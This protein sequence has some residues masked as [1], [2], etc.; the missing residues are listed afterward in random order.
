MDA[1]ASTLVVI[2][3]NIA[4]ATAGP[5]PGKTPTA[6]PTAHPIKHH[7]KLI[8]V[9]A[10]ANPSMSWFQTSIK[11]TLLQLNLAN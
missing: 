8:G 7:N 4:T 11:S 6:V 9:A 5:I 3:S 1:V 2:G 10:V